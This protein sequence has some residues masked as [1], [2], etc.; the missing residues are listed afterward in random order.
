MKRMNFKRCYWSAAD[1]ERLLESSLYRKDHTHSNLVA[2]FDLE[3]SAVTQDEAGKNTIEDELPHDFAFMYIWQ[4]GIEDIVVYGRTWDEL[5]E[6][7]M[8]I[9]A[10]LHLAP[11]YKL[12]VFDQKLKYDFF[13]FK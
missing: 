2:A 5:R 7:L 1:W 6:C 11:D 9:H 3:T 10:A 8:D 4:L 13:F 12:I